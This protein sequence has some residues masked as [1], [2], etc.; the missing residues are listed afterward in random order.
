MLTENM[1]K[2]IYVGNFNYTKIKKK[3]KVSNA[4]AS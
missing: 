4:P 1:I 2:M 3:K